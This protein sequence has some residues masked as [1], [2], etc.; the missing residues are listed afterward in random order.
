[1]G[2][3]DILSL[4]AEAKKA[5]EKNNEVVNAIIGMYLD[6]KTKLGFDTVTKELGRINPNNL[7]P[8]G[9]TTGGNLFED[10]IFKWVFGK[11]AND[12]NKSFYHFTA[13]TPGGSGALNIALSTFGDENTPI[14]TS[15]IRWRYDYFAKSANKKIL[16]HNL[17]NEKE[18]FDL[19]SLE[20]T[21]KE[22]KSN[23]FILVINDPCH[24]PTG[25][26]MSRDEISKIVEIINK[27]EKKA[28][29]IFD[30]AYQDFNPNG[31]ESSHNNLS[32]LINLN[33]NH[34]IAITFSGSKTFGIYGIR[35]GALI[36]LFKDENERN[37]IK[38]EVGENILG[39]WSTTSSV[40]VELIK[41]IFN[42]EEIKN[43][44]THDLTEA[45]DTLKKRGDLFIKEAKE[46]GLGH[47]PYKGGFFVLLKTNNQNK[48]FNDLKEAGI[49]VVPISGG[50]R[51][52][53]SSIGISEIMGLATKIHNIVSQ[54]N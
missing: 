8:Y 53:L 4:A 25:Y 30:I 26:C 36:S 45:R 37:I 20:R 17:F 54:N 7:I 9:E 43:S 5:K 35:L 27:Q 44:F 42:T 15:N 40:G 3:M 19:D 50:L 46:I 14:I 49:Y 52:S 29:I 39:K 11:K 38:E 23:N 21:I 12:I 6:E 1:M 24:N 48:D 22:V 13:A 31:M 18:E 28:L 47:Y 41:N 34:H 33:K 51:I 2:K 32:E 16:E 10:A